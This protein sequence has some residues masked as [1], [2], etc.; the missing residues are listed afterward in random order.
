M[1]KLFAPWRMEYIRG[2]GSDGCECIFCDKPPRLD[3]RS[4]LLLHVGARTLVMM[5]LYPYNNGHIMVAPR[6]HVDSLALLDAGELAALITVVSR[7]IEIM[8]EA[9]KPHGF[10]VGLNLGRVAGAGIDQHLHVH[11]V[12][13]WN[14]DTNFMPLLA[15]TKVVSEH[16]L[17]T[18]DGLKGPFGSMSEQE[19]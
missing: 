7:S 10:N 17:A 3:R 2:G 13:R 15:E 9:F 11:I 14:G 19:T 4:N 12:P 8:R 6:R 1:E 5:N 18:Y 16:I